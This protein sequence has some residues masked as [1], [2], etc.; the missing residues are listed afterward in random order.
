MKKDS[1]PPKYESDAS[2]AKLA[3]GVAVFF[4]QAINI[5]GGI[6]PSKV[7]DK[8]LLQAGARAGTVL[9]EGRAFRRLGRNALFHLRSVPRTQ[10]NRGEEGAERHRD[11]LHLSDVEIH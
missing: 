10:V 8:N 7:S 4:D 9:V 5:S 3:T 11:R 1:N 2:I 6:K